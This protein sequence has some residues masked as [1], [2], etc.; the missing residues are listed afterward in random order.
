MRPRPWR[1]S[2]RWS[3]RAVIFLSCLRP[4]ALA[5][6]AGFALSL[7]Y[8]GVPKAQADAP[9]SFSRTSTSGSFLAARHAGGERDAAAAAS[10]Y[11]AALRGDPRNNELLGRTF[12]A[13]LANGEVEDAVKLAERVLQTDKNDRIARLVLGVRALKQKQYPAARRELAQSIRGPITDLAATLLSAW[14][15]ANPNEA[16]Q[17]TDSID[18]LAG[19]DWYAIFK[20]L[21]AALILD[22]AGQKREAAKRFERCYKRDPTALRV[23]QSYGSFLS[24]RGNT[25]DAMKVFAAF[26]EAMPRHPLVVEATSELKA[27]KKLPLM[28]DTPQAGAAEVLYGLGASLG[29]LGGEDLGLIYLQLSLYLAPSHPLTLLSLG[30]LY[31]A[32]KKPEMANKTY[33]RV[34][35]NSP[36]QR[37]A[38]IQ[39]ALNLDALD[40]TDEAKASL[41]K[42]IAANPSDLEA[43][44]ALG[45]VLRGRKQFAECADVYSKGVDTIGK[46][47]KSN[48]VIYYFRGI[49]FERSKQWPK[50]EADFK[51]SLDL[52]PDQPHVLNYLGYSWIDQGINLDDGMRM[53]KRAVEQRADDGY[54]VDSLGWA[55]YRLGNMEEAV[56][57]PQARGY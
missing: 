21:H 10:Y 45:N 20:E 34:P 29:R 7:S 57:D 53:I 56:H 1:S 3:R 51:R 54:I 31:E 13:L 41:E 17:A 9:S 33:E 14:T 19:A 5:A 27:G 37:N 35:L 30:D 18:K 22:V 11:R 43:I 48:W 39:L 36:L 46:P 44:M 8:P 49:C 50:A 4:A 52:F 6:V 23:V 15:M 12:L 2:A 24:R 55:Y 32:M 40:R 25:A 16:K 28:V 47:E 26:D 42:V 38:Q